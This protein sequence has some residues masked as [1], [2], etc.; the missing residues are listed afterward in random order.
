MA[1]CSCMSTTRSR[2]S[3]S[4]ATTGRAARRTRPL[5]TS[6]CAPPHAGTQLTRHEITRAAHKALEKCARENSKWTRADMIA[7]LGRVLP[8]HAADPDCQARLLEDV[9]DQVLAGEFG[10]V[11]CLESPEAA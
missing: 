5:I 3:R 7:N 4:R 11:V 10:P 2:M 8:R 6:T 9:A 1:T